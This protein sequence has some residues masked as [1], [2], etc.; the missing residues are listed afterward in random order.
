MLKKRAKVTQWQMP[1]PPG[2]PDPK[3]GLVSEVRPRVIFA[4]PEEQFPT[5]VTRWSFA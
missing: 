2:I 1:I 3:K 4:M 5:G